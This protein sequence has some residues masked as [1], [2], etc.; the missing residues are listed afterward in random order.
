M[1]PQ[2]DVLTGSS[3]GPQAAQ[4]FGAIAAAAWQQQ[5]RTQHPASGPD[6]GQRSDVM[7]LFSGGIFDEGYNVGRAPICVPLP[8][9]VRRVLLVSV[10]TGAMTYVRCLET[11]VHANQASFCRGPLATCVSSYSHA[12]YL[13]VDVSRCSV[14][15]ELSVLRCQQLCQHCIGLI[16]ASASQ[17]MGTTTTSAQSFARA[18][19]ISRSMGGN[20]C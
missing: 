6:N 18:A 12:V 2:P 11:V 3:T 8:A 15:F 19:I 9:D 1:Q 14:R 10:I 16:S 7:P 20:T 5:H 17:D 13:E 4:P